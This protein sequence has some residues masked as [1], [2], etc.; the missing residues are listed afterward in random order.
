MPRPADERPPPEG[1]TVLRH[2][3]TPRQ[4]SE[5]TLAR[6]WIGS[7]GFALIIESLEGDARG[8]CKRRLRDERRTEDVDEITTAWR[9]VSARQPVQAYLTNEARAG[10][11]GIERALALRAR[12][13]P[14]SFEPLDERIAREYRHEIEWA[15]NTSSPLGK[16]FDNAPLPDWMPDHR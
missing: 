9:I 11:G 2:P 3:K 6:L 1:C 13:V 4:P 7:G 14:V 5:Q 8:R 10:A 12:G 15:N 16:L